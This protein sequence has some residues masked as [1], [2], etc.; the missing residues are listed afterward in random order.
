ML[1]NFFKSIRPGVFIILGLCYLAVGIF[2]AQPSVATPAYMLPGRLILN[3]LMYW[4]ILHHAL[5]G[6][7]IILL[8]F[9]V[10]FFTVRAG[11]FKNSNS[12]T[13]L[14][15]LLWLMY[16]PESF[17][18]LS[19]VIAVF[20]SSAGVFLLGYSFSA[21]RDSFYTFNASVLFALSALNYWPF[22]LMILLPWLSFIVNGI[23]AW[24]VWVVALLGPLA[25][26][27][28]YFSIW[29]WTND[30]GHYGYTNQVMNWYGNGLSH[31][32]R[33]PEVAYRNVTVLLITLYSLYE[34]QRNFSRKKVQ[35]RR[36][37]SLLLLA[38]TI[39][40]L[41]WLLSPSASNEA[42][43]LLG[44]FCAI[45]Y[46]NTF[47]YFRSKWYWDLVLIMLFAISAVPFFVGE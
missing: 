22:V 8:G 41:I 24:R 3:E 23:T 17:N 29:I 20:L 32:W 36:V 25:I 42:A 30:E 19:I 4:P 26:G 15:F 1:I 12:L 37:F 40:S 35:N 39:A 10:N 45:F 21:N 43:L 27:L 6:V 13:G 5:I 16:F 18:N 34:L 9:R 7:G 11:L 44:V 2:Y 46:S 14:F 47:Y 38:A 28:I 31:I 33:T